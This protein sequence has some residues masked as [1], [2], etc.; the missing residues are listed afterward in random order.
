MT[1]QWQKKAAGAQRWADISGATAS[2]RALT[3]QL[4]ANTGDQYRVILGSSSG[5]VK[6]TSNA[7]TLTFGT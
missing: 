1:Y 7:A 6:V 3:G 2:T 4:A 5:A